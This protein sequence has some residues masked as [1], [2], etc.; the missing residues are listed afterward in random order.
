MTTTA[1]TKAVCALFACLALTSSLSAQQFP[2]IPDAPKT[3]VQPESADQREKREALADAER[4]AAAA[5]FAPWK[6]TPLSTLPGAPVSIDQYNSLKK[7]GAVTLAERLRHEEDTEEGALQIALEK[8]QWPRSF[9][10]P[11]GSRAV[12]SHFT[13]GFP[14]YSINLGLFEAH[15]V[16][17]DQLWP[18]GSLGL[19]LDGSGV[20][21]GMWEPSLVETNHAEFSTGVERVTTIGSGSPDDHATAVAGII[22]AAG[23]DTNAIGASYNGTLRSHLLANQFSSMASEATNGMLISNH[24]YGQIMGWDTVVIGGH[25]RVAW[26]G[27]T[28]ISADEDYRFGF[29][30]TEAH[31]VDDIQYHNPYYLSVWAAGNERGQSGGTTIGPGDPHY[32]WSGSLQDFVYTTMSHGAGAGYLNDGD[33][34]QYDTLHPYQSAKNSLVVGS[35][36]TNG[37]LSTTSSLGPTDDG[38]IKPDLVAP[39]EGVYAPYPYAGYWYY[40]GTSFSSPTVA[41]SLNLL[42]QLWQQSAPRPM[43]ASTVR[44]VAIHTAAPVLYENSPS[45]SSGWGLLS[46]SNAAR[47]VSMNATNSKSFIKEV[48]FTNGDYIEFPVTGDGS[49]AIKI[50]ICWTDPAAAANSAAVDPTNSALVNDL[51]LRV[52]DSSGTTNFPFCLNPDFAG[53]S[54]GTRSG[55]ATNG[56]NTVDNVEQVYI[57]AT[58]DTFTVRV[59]HKNTLYDGH[60]QV[61][62]FMSGTVPQP[63]PAL[64][65]S[66]Q[67]FTDTNKFTIQ[68][69]AVVGQLYEV[70]YKD[71]LNSTNWVI[72]GQIS[73]TKTNVAVDMPASISASNRFYRVVAVP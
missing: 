1:S 72:S 68:W 38:R 36:R 20:P 14:H 58:N 26:Y 16:G 37:T 63:A 41:G 66:R 71:D 11:D 15:M 5:A 49:N 50:T 29:Y 60:Q 48:L 46:V 45:Y 35:V 51:D 4:K 3:E 70:H 21:I 28:D 73:A 19:S 2:P 39:G 10:K 6:H 69:P 42:Q 40:S 44:G 9:V 31:T 65:I 61:S 12:L 22:M 18:G 67:A 7:T 23:I 43:L 62:I 55:P 13:K 27:D 30:G 25:S 32:A 56:D 59:T 17:A 54:S 33:E 8:K 47:L 53:K 24:S 52:I 64:L 34:G 57:G